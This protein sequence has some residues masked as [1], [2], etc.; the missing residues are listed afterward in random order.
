[1]HD[2]YIFYATNYDKLTCHLINNIGSYMYLELEF[3]TL[4]LV[5]LIP[6][7]EQIR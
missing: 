5:T 1:M 3:I 2:I 4:L 6:L 7:I